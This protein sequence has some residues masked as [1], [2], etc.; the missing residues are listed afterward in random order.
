MIP[1]KRYQ[2][3]KNIAWCRNCDGETIWAW[4][5]RLGLARCLGCGVSSNDFY[6]R[7]DNGLNTDFAHERFLRACRSRRWEKPENEPGLLF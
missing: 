6:F 1:P 4:D 7:K 3:K 2:P 5:R